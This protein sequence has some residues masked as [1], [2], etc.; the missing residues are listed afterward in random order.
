M[1]TARR[2]EETKK[3]G[4]TRWRCINMLQ[5]V[6]VGRKSTATSSVLD[7]N[8]N[9]TP[10]IESTQARFGRHFERV[11]NVPLEFNADVVNSMPELE[12]REDLDTVPAF[13]ELQHALGNMKRG[14][15]AGQSAILASSRNLCFVKV[16]FFSVAFMS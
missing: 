13:E 8:G 2:A 10:D 1:K 3:D 9:A 11:L 15:A 4:R 16:K 5:G 12:V 6:H 14:T 7:E